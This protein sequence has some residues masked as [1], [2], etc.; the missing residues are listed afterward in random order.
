MGRFENVFAGCAADIRI[1]FLKAFLLSFLSH[2]PPLTI[3]A[4]PFI[5]LLPSLLIAMKTLQ[6]F[7]DDDANQAFFV[8]FNKVD[9]F[10]CTQPIFNKRLAAMQA[11]GNELRRKG[12]GLGHV[13]LTV[14]VDHACHIL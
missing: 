14:V 4:N 7:P 1:F 10:Q 13:N 11:L 5:S 2:T 9:L 8:A 3:A 12:L 6:F